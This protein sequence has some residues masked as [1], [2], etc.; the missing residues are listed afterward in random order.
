MSSPIA[1]VLAFG[2]VCAAAALVAR[3]VGRRLGSRETLF[4]AALTVA[5]LAPGFTSRRTILP[6][7]HAMLLAPWSHTAAGAGPRYNAN[8]NDAITQIAP[9]T[10]AVRM[11][12]KEGSL[13][14]RNRWNGAGMALAGNGQSAAWSPFTFLTLPLALAAAFNLLAAAKIFLALAGTSLWLRGLGLGRPAAAFGAVLF[15]LSFNFANWLLLPP[16]AVFALFPWA[17]YAIEANATSIADADAAAGSDERL[18]SSPGRA[19]A[20]LVAVFAA[21]PLCGHPESVVLC[22]GFATAWLA[23]RALLGGLHGVARLTGRIALAAALAIGLTAFLTVPEA[24]AIR[25]SNRMRFAEAFRHALPSSVVPH[26]PL[27]P[28]GFLTALFPRALGDA[29]DSPMIPGGVGNFTEMGL[30]FFGI[31][32]AATALLVLRPGSR[33]SKAA[34]A[35][36]VPLAAGLAIP[37]G[38]WP[39][40]DA[41]IHLP[42]LRLMFVLRWFS[43]AS[44]AGAALAAFEAERL[45]RD[46]ASSFRALRE[47]PTAASPRFAPDPISKAPTAAAIAAVLIGGG[48]AALGWAAWRHYAP[49][50][51]AAGGSASQKHALVS[52]LAAAAAF[53]TISIA[54]SLRRLTTAVAPRIPLFLCAAAAFELGLQD[55]RIYRFG[56][57]ARLFPETPLVRFLHSRPAPFRASGDAAVLF[58]GS[59]VF[60]GVEDI[61]THDPVEREDYVDFLD[62][63]A[64]Y[65]PADYFKKI[66]DWTAPELDLVNLV[67]LAGEPGQSFPGEKWRRVYDGTD[68]VVYENADALPRVFAAVRIPPAARHD[69]NGFETSEYRESTNAIAFRTRSDRPVPAVVS[70]VQ[71]GGWRARDESGREIPTARAAGVLVG[72]EIPAGEHAIHLRYLPPGFSA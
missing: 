33:R 39:L 48:I 1:V 57:P 59:N 67:Y 72:L 4:F 13:P 36:L 29:I 22:A 53:V 40:Y 5:L 32:G 17:L 37:T 6:V 7:D 15:G 50:H 64:G 63:A 62:R 28:A 14:L 31:V 10:K 60:A 52:T 35:F 24:V 27:I 61:R 65:P 9:W 42:V 20:L 71:D 3:W 54:G 23:A 25:A 19:F 16:T 34:L 30:G 46:L 68:G 45:A 47:A 18:R 38:T 41:A 11:A 8:L 51:A 44:F 12:W 43:W 49:L 21:W 56:D 69:A 58:P 70:V 2:G 66:H 26:G 55:A